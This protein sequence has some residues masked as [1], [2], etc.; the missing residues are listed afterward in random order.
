MLA[1]R[2]GN[3]WLGGNTRTD[4]AFAGGQVPA[5]RYARRAARQFR[6]RYLAGS[7]RQPLVGTNAGLARRDGDQFVAPHRND[8][9]DRE[10]VRALFEDR[11]GDVWVGTSSGLTRLR[12]AMFT[13]FGKSEGL[14]SDEPNTMFQDRRGRVWVGFHDGGLMLFSDERQSRLRTTRDGLPNHGDLLHPARPATATC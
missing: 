9:R 5:I 4:H 2:N 6:A 3:F 13:V 14:P 12:D 7:R 8:G 10:Q 1:G 11:E